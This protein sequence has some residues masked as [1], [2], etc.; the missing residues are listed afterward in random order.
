MSEITVHC[1]IQN[2]DVVSIGLKFTDLVRE[3]IIEKLELNRM[4]YDVFYDGEEIMSDQQTQDTVIQDGSTLNIAYNK[5]LEQDI[6]F[7]LKHSDGKVNLYDEKDV[8]AAVVAIVEGGNR[9]LEVLK[10]CYR[11]VRRL[12]LATA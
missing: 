10:P 1:D 4:M 9:N 6:A 11:I 8:G 5:E 2:K 7:V 3:T 12:G